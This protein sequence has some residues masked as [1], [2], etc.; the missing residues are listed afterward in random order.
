MLSHE[1][2]LVSDPDVKNQLATALASWTQTDFENRL[3][4]ASQQFGIEQM[5][6]FFGAP[7]V[8]GLPA[9]INEDSLKIDRV[10][11]L[12]A[13]L[14]D[15]ETKQRGSEALVTLAKR[16]ESAEWEKKTRAL[17]DESNRKNKSTATEAQIQVQIKMYQDNEL[18]KVFSGIKRLGMRPSVE[19]ALNYAGDVR[20]PE[21]RRKLALSALEQRIDKAD[22]EKIFAIVAADDTPDVVRDLAVLR[23]G[24]LPKNV[25]QA[26]IY[27]LFEGKSWKVRYGAASLL[28]RSLT[29]KEIPEFMRRLPATAATKMA[30]T[31][32]L[33]YGPQIAHM[34]PAAGDPK[35]REA[36]LPH[37]SSASLGAKLTAIG[38][39]YGGKKADQGVLKPY[40]E[41]KQPVPKCEE[42]DACEWTCTVPK[43]GNAKET[44]SRPV[45]TVGDFVKLCVI[46][47]MDQP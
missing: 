8:K 35:P 5:M 6:R 22:M 14:G 24:E 30:M 33:T 15:A 44:E 45:A 25:I 12:I 23:L 20:R 1:P 37:L 13:D 43:A 17:V 38:S 46:P 10:A 32:P 26:K 11:G 42:K 4:N 34:E 16:V 18:Q 3:E 39:F 2:S 40:E 47:S 28:L 41:D 29:T 27:S 9:L 21:D 7:S 36:I 19:Y 31:E